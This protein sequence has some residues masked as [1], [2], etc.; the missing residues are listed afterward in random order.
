MGFMPTR[1]RPRAARRPTHVIFVAVLRTAAAS[2]LGA[3]VRALSSVCFASW[4]QLDRARRHLMPFAV[5]MESLNSTP[6]EK[7]RILNAIAPSLLVGGGGDSNDSLLAR[8]DV[9]DGNVDRANNGSGLD[10]LPDDLAHVVA[11]LSPDAQRRMQ[12]LLQVAQQQQ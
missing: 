1:A 3:S 2:A 8:S 9:A 7:W 5:L 11:N 6:Q 12:R 4:Q 10:Q